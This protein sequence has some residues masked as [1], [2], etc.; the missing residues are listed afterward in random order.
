MAEKPTEREDPTPDAEVRLTSDQFEMLIRCVPKKHG[1]VRLRDLGG[2]H[3]EI[4]VLDTAGNVMKSRRLYPPSVE[5]AS[6]STFRRFLK[7]RGHGEQK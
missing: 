4:E 5:R 1:G 7:E 6:P 3:V 2:A